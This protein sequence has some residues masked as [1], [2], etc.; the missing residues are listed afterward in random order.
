MTPRHTLLVAAAIALTP[1]A[2]SASDNLAGSFDP[3]SFT[4]QRGRGEERAPR[5]GRGRE[6]GRESEPGRGSASGERSSVD[7]PAVDLARRYF[8][9]CDQDGD[10]FMSFYEAR[11][12]LD[13]DRNEFGVYDLTGDGLCDED[14]FRERY[15]AV[16]AKGGAFTPPRTADQPEDAR[17]RSRALELIQEHDSDKDTLIGIDEVEEIL[18]AH[19]IEGA[20]LELLMSIVDVDGSRRLDASEV[21]RLLPL[22]TREVDTTGFM[23]APARSIEELFGMP[24]EREGGPDWAPEPPRIKGP[25]PTFY[26]LDLDRDGNVTEEDL[27]HLLRPL[28]LPVRLGTVIANLDGDRDGGLSRAELKRSMTRP[29]PE[30]GQ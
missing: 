2:P 24:K 21:V 5:E 29:T 17:K 25:I 27:K 22:L 12:S 14:E 8:H 19:S 4:A 6:P 3:G 18:A 1:L 13:L 23:K 9:M 7:A 15:D 26:R 16:I 10:G 11:S 30:E 28:K 20:D